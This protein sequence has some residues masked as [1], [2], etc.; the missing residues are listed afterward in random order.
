MLQHPRTMV[1]D[2]DRPVFEGRPQQV[3]LSAKGGRTIGLPSPA[4]RIASH[5]Y[6]DINILQRGVLDPECLRF[7]LAAHH[8]GFQPAGQGVGAVLGDHHAG[9]QGVV[10][11]LW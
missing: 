11:I 8:Q 1:F 10:G 9:Q 3:H 5:L 7:V 6:H 4:G 2:Q